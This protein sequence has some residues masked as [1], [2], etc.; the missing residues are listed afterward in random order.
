[1]TEEKLIQVQAPE[2]VTAASVEG[3]E[4]TV[5]KD[6]FFYMLEHH[7][8]ALLEQGF[9]AVVEAGKEL[10]HGVEV[11]LEPAPE[12]PA[13]EE[14]LAASE[15]KA[16]AAAPEVPAAATENLENEGGIPAPAPTEAPEAA[17]GGDGASTPAAEPPAAEKPAA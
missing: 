13:P 12:A 9:N 1:M 16:P 14:P 8:H 6:G 3:R 17:Q 7:L 4:Y 10:V 15:P 11:A 5:E 2:G